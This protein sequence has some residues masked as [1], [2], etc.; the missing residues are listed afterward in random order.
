MTNHATSEGTARYRARMVSLTAPGHYRQQH[1]LWMSSIG[2]GTYLGEPDTATDLAYCN[3]VAAAVE[4]GCNVIDSAINY[5]HQ[6]SERS[7][8]AALRKLFTSGKAQ[9][10]EVVIATKGGFLSFDGEMPPN[11]RDYFV[12][13]FVKTGLCKPNEIAAGCHCMTPAYL[14]DQ[15]DR[16][17]RNLGVECIDIY[18]VHNPETQLSEVPAR[19]FLDRLRAAFETL[20][21]EVDEGRIRMYG[22]ATWNAF[23]SPAGAQEYLSLQELVDVAMDAGGADHHFKVI[24]LPYN[25][26]MPEALTVPNQSFRGEERSTL[27]L[28]AELGI[29]VM[30]SA[31]IFQ[32]RLSHDL[33]GFITSQLKGL[34]TDAQRAIQFVRSTPGLTT[35]LVGMS[36]T[37]HVAENLKAASV[38]PATA[39]EFFGLFGE[40]S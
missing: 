30:A 12:D 17:L 19:I 15:I 10:D 28:A 33:P 6:R 5:R 20:E 27:E 29:T 34:T 40:S 31:S 16:S 9:R 37:E 39:E 25:L 38:S 18:Y 23:R 26:A 1:G 32:S 7:I 13:T 36:R 11:P 35:A 14:K 22:T 21:A 4:H 24:Q 8:G 2:I 3:S